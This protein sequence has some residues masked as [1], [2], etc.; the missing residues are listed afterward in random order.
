MD[1]GKTTKEILQEVLKSQK[2]TP[3]YN[4]EAIALMKKDF[5]VYKNTVVQEKDRKNWVV[6]PKTI[7][8]SNIPRNL[9]YTP[10]DNEDFDYQN[11]LGNAGQAPFTRGLHA[12][13]YRGKS[14][15]LRQLSAPVLRRKLMRE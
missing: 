2:R 7:M 5:D 4:K 10:L 8:G 6:T 11:D 14:W 3:L 1:S 12:N 13:M 15:T 9:T